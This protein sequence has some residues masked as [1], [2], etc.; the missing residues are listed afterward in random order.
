MG[1]STRQPPDGGE[2]A[3][4]ARRPRQARAAETRRRLLEAGFEAFASKGLD[5]VNLVDDVL[6]PAGISIGS[7]YH[8]FADKT[9]L[10]REILQ[11]AAARRRAFIVR[12]GELDPT[13]DLETTV[14]SAVERLYD[15]LEQDAAAWQL[16]RVTRVTG[17]DGVRDLGSTTRESWNDELGQLLGNWFDRPQA[18]LRR[19][20]DLLVTLARGF[21][22]DFLDTPA[23]QRRPRTEQVDT[24]VTFVIGGLT[25]LLGPPRAPH[26]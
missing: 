21:L 20:G 2:G 3:T 4:V 8:Q 10:L 15:S 22:Y 14:R 5:G 18:E 9:A 11:E 1:D 24:L 13:S 23:R 7:F 26:N 17:I 25:A 19:A 6:E 12:L 16:Q